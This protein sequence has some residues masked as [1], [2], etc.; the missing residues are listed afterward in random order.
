VTLDL[1]N[2]AMCDPGWPSATLDLAKCDPGSGQL[3]Q[4]RPWPAMCDPARPS[5]TLPL[6]SIAVPPALALGL[7]AKSRKKGEEKGREGKREGKEKTRR[8]GGM[9]Y[10]GVR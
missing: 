4:V 7:P 8:S 3:D 6:S 5:V 1:A 2:L 9:L 10:A